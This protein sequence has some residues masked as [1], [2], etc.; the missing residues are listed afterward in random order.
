VA[1]DPTTSAPTAVATTASPTPSGRWP[2][3]ELARY[4]PDGAVQLRDGVTVLQR[5][6]APLPSE[7]A[8][9]SVALSLEQDGQETWWLLQWHG[10]GSSGSSSF[11]P[12]G[13]FATIDDWL[14]EQVL[15]NTHPEKVGR[16]DYLTFAED[17]SLVSSHGVQILEQEYPIQLKNFAGPRDRTA[18]ALVQGP[19]DTKWYVLV[20]DLDGQLDVEKVDYGNGGPDLD[21]FLAFAKDAFA[22]GDGLR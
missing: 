5:I 18:A 14:E 9:R 20:R 13:A 4:T 6:E 21:S 10:R 19:D 11:H 2:G 17:G 8:A 15:L 3:D 22:N 7:V 1:T 16:V 12:G